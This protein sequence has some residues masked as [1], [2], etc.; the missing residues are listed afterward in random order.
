[1]GKGSSGCEETLGTEMVDRWFG[2]AG[3]E[4]LCVCVFH[5]VSRSSVTEGYKSG[6]KKRES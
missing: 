6:T 1:M 3:M 5:V 4:R 2:K